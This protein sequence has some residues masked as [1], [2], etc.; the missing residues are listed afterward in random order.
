MIDL[1]KKAKQDDLAMKCTAVGAFVALPITFAVASPGGALVAYVFWWA[2]IGGA[3]YF[4]M[5]GTKRE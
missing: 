5:K 1:E 3:A 4:L 2:V